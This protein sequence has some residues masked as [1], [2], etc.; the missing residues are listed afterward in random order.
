MAVFA[1]SYFFRRPTFTG[2]Q[3]G[4]ALFWV[5]NGMAIDAAPVVVANLRALYRRAPLPG[6][7]NANRALPLLRKCPI[8]LV[9]RQG[10]EP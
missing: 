4:A 7:P 8:V 6:A 5:M 2:I 10:L 3:A 1:S 9:G